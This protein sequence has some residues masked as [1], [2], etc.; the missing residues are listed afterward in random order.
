VEVV[1]DGSKPQRDTFRFVV[2]WKEG[3]HFAEVSAK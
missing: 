1:V 2:D 3:S